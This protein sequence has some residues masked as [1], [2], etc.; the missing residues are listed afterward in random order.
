MRQRKK[1]M[2]HFKH[3]MIKQKNIQ[4]IFFGFLLEEYM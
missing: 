4:E 2:L 3:F 1:T